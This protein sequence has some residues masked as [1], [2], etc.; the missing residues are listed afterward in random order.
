MN[1]ANTE[2]QIA[3]N[4]SQEHALVFHA[5]RIALTNYLEA[6]QTYRHSPETTTK[7]DVD[8]ALDILQEL[9]HKMNDAL[10]IID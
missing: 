9:T 6:L 4:I 3:E 1:E 2:Q 8:D 5:Y 7:K 10:Q